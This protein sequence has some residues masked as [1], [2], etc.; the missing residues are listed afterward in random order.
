[1][2]NVYEDLF[3]PNEIIRGSAGLTM[4]NN[5]VNGR[6]MYF[7][8]SDDEKAQMLEIA[9]T[10]G[11]PPFTNVVLTL[12]ARANEEGELTYTQSMVVPEIL[13]PEDDDDDSTIWPEEEFEPHAHELEWAGI[14]APH[15]SFGKNTR[16]SRK[17]TR[18]SN[19]KTRKTRKKSRKRKIF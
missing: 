12:I 15:P 10:I 19:K 9:T 13:P 7:L 4:M 8:L 6:I 11:F 14:I 3:H 18:K 17:K 1:M 16:K 2:N 5:R